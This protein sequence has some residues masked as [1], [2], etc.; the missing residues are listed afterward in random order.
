MKRDPGFQYTI[1]G[2]PKDVDRVL[3]QRAAQ[4][5]ASLNKVIVDELVAATTGQKECADFSDV[6]GLWTPDPNFDEVIAAQRQI[7]P[8]KWK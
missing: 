2:V 3:R 8:D 6:T 4:R 1:R 7:D 5:N